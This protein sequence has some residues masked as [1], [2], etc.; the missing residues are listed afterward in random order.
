MLGIGVA[1]LGREPAGRGDPVES[2]LVTERGEAFD[3]KVEEDRL[4]VVSRAKAGEFEREMGE[5]WNEQ[6]FDEA[7]SVFGSW[8][9]N[10]AK[11]ALTFLNEMRLPLVATHFA[12]EV[13]SYF[14]TLEAREALALTLLITS[15]HRLQ[16]TVA[17]DR[18]R[19]WL[20]EDLGGSLRWM[21]DHGETAF[22]EDLA[23]E[24]GIEGVFGAPEEGLGRALAL[25]ESEVRARMVKGIFREWM[26]K[27]PEAAVAF[28]GQAP[29]TGA[30]DQA[31][32]AEVDLMK[33]DDPEAALAWVKALQSESLRAMLVVELE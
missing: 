8:L 25:P 5:L 10:D 28:L 4:L 18:L 11:G 27:D 9:R 21:S 33:E 32:V 29:E 31:I 7:A 22:V 14:E 2:V 1:F 23:E 3:S 12:D 19:A 13:R 24:L 15:D 30:F 17:L 20:R 6:R 26:R 16:S